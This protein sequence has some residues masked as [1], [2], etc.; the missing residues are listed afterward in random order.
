VQFPVPGRCE[1]VG[2]SAAEAARGGG[3]VVAEVVDPHDPG[4]A[5]EVDTSDRGS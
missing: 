4:L 1:G 2:V 5:V 3:L